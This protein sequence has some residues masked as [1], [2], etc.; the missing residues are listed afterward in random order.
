MSDMAFDDPEGVNVSGTVLEPAEPVTTSFEVEPEEEEQVAYYEERLAELEAEPSEEFQDGYRSALEEQGYRIPVEPGEE[1]YNEYIQSEL[2]D[3][4]DRQLQLLEAWH[5]L[6]PVS[7]NQVAEKLIANL[8]GSRNARAEMNEAAARQVQEDFD[9]GAEHLSGLIS[10]TAELVGMDDGAVNP[11]E[12]AEVAADVY[13]E[14]EKR[15]GKEVA[16]QLVDTIVQRTTAH[17]A[18]ESEENLSGLH[19]K[20]EKLIKDLGNR[21]T[22]PEVVDLASAIYQRELFHA[23]GD[24]TEAARSALMQAAKAASGFTEKSQPAEMSLASLHAS[25]NRAIPR[26]PEPQPKLE[27]QL[28]RDANGRFVARDSV[29]EKYRPP[30]PRSEAEALADAQKEALRRAFAPYA[31]SPHTPRR[32]A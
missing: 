16:D 1:G 22:S 14:V 18:N 15:H 28:K 19:E 20:A 27:V 21:A 6:D 7:A 23:K 9:R 30:A 31:N 25:L 2:K 24:Q 5:E 17:L 11:Q 29:A 26:Q 3:E 32:D 4:Q 10:E 8:E 12:A 13:A